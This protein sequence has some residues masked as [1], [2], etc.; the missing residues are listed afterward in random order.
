MFCVVLP[1]MMLTLSDQFHRHQFE[2]SLFKSLNDMPDLLSLRSVWLDHNK[3]PF[4]RPSKL[5][6]LSHHRLN[7]ILENVFQFVVGYG[8]TLELFILLLFWGFLV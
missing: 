5:P 8:F 7:Q 3:R 2:T 1:E 6:L 4:S